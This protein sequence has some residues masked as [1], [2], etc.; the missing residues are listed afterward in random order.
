MQVGEVLLDVV[1][2][3]IGHGSEPS[4]VPASVP[5]VRL[6][7]WN[8][9]HG[10]DPSDGVVDAQRLAEAVAALDADVLCLQEVDRDQPRSGLVDQ[11]AVV[12][13][14]LGAQAWRFEAAI[15]GTPDERW[16]PI[17]NAPAI[18]AAYG[19]GLVSRLP[20]RSWHLRRLD[21]PRVPMLMPGAV[22]ERGR[23]GVR[24]GRPQVIRDTPRVVL[25]AVVETGRG[26][27]TVGCCHLTYVQGWNV[28][29][30]R[31]ALTLLR[32][33]PAP[34]FLLGDF[35]MAGRL[36]ALTSQWRPLARGRT[37][38][39]WRPRLQIDHALAEGHVEVLG[40]QIVELPVSDHR[41][42]VV[43]IDDSPRPIR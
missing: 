33:L 36:P 20:V 4:D 28:T 37:F 12:A 32:P 11:T 38:P 26:P 2:D 6:A 35:N 16:T 17:G 22:P 29:Q 41:A 9:L 19:V 31:Q 30:L 40:S 13:E 3:G 42:V 18:G 10:V 5:V 23:N 8:L 34:R 39:A 7:S 27:M 43:D 25:A 21:P 24:L 15:S 1:T 14:A